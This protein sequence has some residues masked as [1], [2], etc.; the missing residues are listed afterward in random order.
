VS[1]YGEVDLAILRYLAFGL[2]ALALMA[3]S[4]RFRPGRLSLR[5]AGLAMFLGLTGYVVYYLCVA[6]SVSLAGPAIAPLVIGALPVVLAVYGNWRER[7]VPWRRIAVPLTLVVLG[8]LTLN[9]GSLAA[10]GGAAER[11]RIWQGVA[12]AVGALLVWV[13]YAIVNA[14]E[15]RATDAPP[16]LAWTA[17]QGLGAMAGVLP[18]AALAPLLGLGR[19][20]ELGFQFPAATPLVLW[21][22]MTGVVGSFVAQ[23]LWTHASMRLPLAFSAQLIVSETVFALVYGFLFEQRWPHP[24]EA[25]AIVLLLVGVLAAVRVFAKGERGAAAPP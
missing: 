2:T 12:L 9:A 6:F 24:H 4:P 15:M 7:N 8:L 21:A 13:W 14:R 1:P 18:L 23:L 11:L 10:A 3:V 25:A 16:P 17:L 22:L 5:R 20:P 19:L